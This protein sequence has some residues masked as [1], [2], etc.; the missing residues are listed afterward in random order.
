MSQGWRLHA[1]R[2]GRRHGPAR[3]RDG[4]PER[5][6]RPYAPELAPAGSHTRT[7]A[8]P[9]PSQEPRLRKAATLR[10]C[11]GDCDFSRPPP[12]PKARSPTPEPRRR[13]PRPSQEPRPHTPAQGPQPYASLNRHPRLH[14]PGGHAPPRP[15][16]GVTTTRLHQRAQPYA[17]VGARRL[18][19]PGQSRDPATSTAPAASHTRT[20]A[21]PRP[22]SGHSAQLSLSTCC[23]APRPFVMSSWISSAVSAY[24]VLASS[25]DLANTTPYTLPSGVSS[26]PPELPWRT[27]A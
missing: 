5:G 16:P 19:R 11:V 22:G 2:R 7:G 8:T 25:R 12:A 23:A 4:T 1:P 9:R 3:S 15:I 27:V 24:P 26:G 21:P 10:T 18:T 20:G 17:R 14:A 13:A 6:L